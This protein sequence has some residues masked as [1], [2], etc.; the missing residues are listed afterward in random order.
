MNF[1]DSLKRNT[2]YI[3]TEN[4]AI[5]HKTTLNAVYDLFAFGGAYRNRNDEDCILLFKKAYE[6]DPILA[7]RCLFYI[8]DVRGG[9]GE[10]RFF[11][12]CYNWLAKNDKETAFRNLDLIP[13]YGRWDDLYCQMHM[14][15]CTLN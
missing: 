3:E 15:L 10:R 5:S 12:V 8:R 1:I 6:Q 11:R 13:T 14:I 4:N 9:L 2:N 7:L